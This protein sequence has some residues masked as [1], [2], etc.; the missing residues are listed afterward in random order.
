METAFASFASTVGTG[1]APAF[2]ATPPPGAVGF[3]AQ[4]A[5]PYPETHADAGDQIGSLIDT[6]MRTG[7]AVPSGGGSPVP[8]S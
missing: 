1:M 6:W 7:T 5:G 4:F 3:A 2:I 8:W